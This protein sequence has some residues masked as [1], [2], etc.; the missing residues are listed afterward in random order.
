MPWV[1]FQTV[2]CFAYLHCW[3]HIKSLLVHSS[4]TLSLPL[5][6]LLPHFSCLCNAFF[7]PIS[8]HRRARQ[9]IVFTILLSSAI[10]HSCL[11][12]D[13]YSYSVHGFLFLYLN[14]ANSLKLIW[15]DYYKHR[16]YMR[17]LLTYWKTA[18]YSSNMSTLFNIRACTPNKTASQNYY[19]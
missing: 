4:S 12:F 16:W 1:F 10:R 14:T 13:C 5:S 3:V 18:I 19:F 8:F 11:Y 2:F 6:P 9:S 7:P 15:L 17:C